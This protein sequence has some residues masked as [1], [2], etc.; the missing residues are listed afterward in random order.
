VSGQLPPAQEQRGV[1][2]IAAVRAAVGPHTEILIDAH[3]RFDVPTAIRLSRRLEP[4]DIGWFEEPVPAESLAALRQ[5]RD[6]TS[7][8]ICV[9]ER[10]Y[11]RYDFAPVL[12]A[13]AADYLMPDVT[14]TGGISE[15]KKIATLAEAYYVPISPHDAGGPVNILAGGHVMLTV[16]NAHK[17]ET[18]R[19]TLQSYD[20][21]I[22]TPLD[23]R[24]GHLHLPGRPGLGIDMNIEALR[25]RLVPDTR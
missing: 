1:D 8:P 4:Y 24:D 21:F 7:I 22:D 13:R 11:T 17:L 15:L 2:I 19:A 20:A 16:P 6:A 9:G 12:E 3:G 14:W 23:I 10:L 18:C 5:V 25:E